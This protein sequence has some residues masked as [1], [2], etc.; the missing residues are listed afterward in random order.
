MLLR[1][2]LVTKYES[3]KAGAIP[4]F[5]GESTQESF[6]P[7][8]IGRYQRIERGLANQLVENGVPLYKQESFPSPS[9]SPSRE[10]GRKRKSTPSNWSSF[11][12]GWCFSLPFT[13]LYRPAGRG[14]VPPILRIYMAFFSLACAFVP[15]SFKSKEASSG[16]DRDGALA[17]LTAGE[18]SLEKR[19]RG[20]FEF[21]L[22]V[23]RIRSFSVTCRKFALSVGCSYDSCGSWIFGC[24]VCV[25]LQVAKCKGKADSA[26]TPC[27]QGTVVQAVKVHNPG[28]YQ[29]TRKASQPDVSA[30]SLG[31]ARGLKRAGCSL[32]KEKLDTKAGRSK[33]QSP[34]SKGA[35]ELIVLWDMEQDFGALRNMTEEAKVTMAAMY[36][37]GDAK[38]WWRTKM[39]D[40]RN[41]RLQ[42]L[43]RQRLKKAPK[44][45][46]KS[47][48]LKAQIEPKRTEKKGSTCPLQ[49]S[50]FGPLKV[51]KKKHKGGPF[52]IGRAKPLGYSGK[53][54]LVETAEGQV[55]GVTAG[56]HQ[57]LGITEK[58]LLALLGPV[59]QTNDSL[60]KE[61]ERVFPSENPV[62]WGEGPP[63]GRLVD[64]FSHLSRRKVALLLLLYRFDSCVKKKGTKELGAEE[65]GW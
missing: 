33:C 47:S 46:A 56:E 42:V 18:L 19:K 59:G 16:R 26:A 62:L 61:I 22:F 35:R 54:R 63:S 27:Q 21:P 34:A 65:W 4:C 51:S 44:P 9:F 1:L 57:R 60:L 30:L 49:L 29:S 39:E 32:E 24:L 64:P 41:G 28:W 17:W 36:L 25:L 58:T 2:E 5:H 40:I 38:L 55:R 3:S 12:A 48:E 53:C 45:E 6:Q 13:S 23:D 37:D 8:S 52:G 31:Q 15:H 14:R 50:Y 11:L 43:Q 7:L 20:V 10:S